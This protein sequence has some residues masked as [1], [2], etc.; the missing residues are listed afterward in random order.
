ME[1]ICFAMHISLFYF[2]VAV[3]TGF[4]IEILLLSLR[5]RGS[6]YQV[7]FHPEAGGILATQRHKGLGKYSSIDQEIKVTNFSVNDE[8]IYYSKLGSDFKISRVDGVVFR[9]NQPSQHICREVSGDLV[10]AA[11]RQ[12]NGRS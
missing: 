6:N 4:N 3:F 9:D 2:H 5:S 12:F 11:R 1:R 10:I 8:G 7:S